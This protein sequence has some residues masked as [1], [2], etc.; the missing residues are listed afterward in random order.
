MK[1]RTSADF[2]PMSNIAGVP[3]VN[4]ATSFGGFLIGSEQ[5]A[6]PGA[7]L[8]KLR[9]AAMMNQKVWPSR[10]ESR[11]CCPVIL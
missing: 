4:R 1:P 2:E 9:D 10:Y 11:V 5:K 6:F 3:Q 7:R 8:T